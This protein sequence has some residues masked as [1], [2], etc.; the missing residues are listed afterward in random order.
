[1]EWWRRGGPHIADALREAGKEF[2]EATFSAAGHGF[3]C[4]ARSS[5]H[6]AAAREAFALA[7]AFLAEGLV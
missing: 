4:D 5:Y 1:M 7:D 6:A 2:A 3:A